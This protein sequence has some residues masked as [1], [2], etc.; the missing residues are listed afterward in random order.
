MFVV[1]FENHLFIKNKKQKSKQIRTLKRASESPSVVLVTRKK[2]INNDELWSKADM[3]V[4]VKYDTDLF[5]GTTMYQYHATCIYGWSS[6]AIKELL[7]IDGHHSVRY[8]RYTPCHIFNYNEFDKLFMAYI[9]SDI[10]WLWNLLQF[11]IQYIIQF[12]IHSRQYLMI[13]SFL[14]LILICVSCMF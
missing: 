3:S 6:S 14:T 7:I 5:V 8:P 10:M 4:C 9:K 13:K 12:I 1:T 11:H 2:R